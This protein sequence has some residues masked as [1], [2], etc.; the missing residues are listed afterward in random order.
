MP[1]PA[2]RIQTEVKAALKAGD[3]ERVATLRLLSSAIQ[4]ET[5]RA[6]AEVDEEGFIRLVRK[7][8]KQRRE[9]AEQ[10]RVGGREELAEREEREADIL[11]VYLPEEV[12]EEELRAAIV[13]LVEERS[14]AGPAAMGQ[15]MK[16]MMTRFAG[17][18]DG[19]VINRLAREVLGG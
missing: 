11:A 17:R 3:R 14:L 16:E 7:A 9:S 12:G 6:G 8:L 1:T 13:A 18:A 4:N 2:E 15:V 10:Y 19:G 5:I